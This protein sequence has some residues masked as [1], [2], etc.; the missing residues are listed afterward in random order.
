LFFLL[1][2]P[3]LLCFQNLC[4]TTLFCCSLTILPLP[5][6]RCLWNTFTS[7]RYKLLY[8]VYC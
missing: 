1:S 4:L 8:T 3:P 6:L 2:F 5:F 7:V